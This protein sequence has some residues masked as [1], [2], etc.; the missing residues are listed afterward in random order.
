MFVEAQRTALIQ[1]TDIA[2]ETKPVTSAEEAIAAAR[3]RLLQRGS[4]PTLK[5]HQA[6]E[7]ADRLVEATLRRLQEIAR[8][9][10]TQIATQGYSFRA[11]AGPEA[12]KNAI[13][14]AIDDLAE[15]LE[16]V[17]L[18]LST[19]FVSR[20]TISFQSV[21]PRYHGL[22][23]A[24]AYFGPD[25]SRPQPL[26]VGT[27]QINYEESPSDAQERFGVWLERVVVA[28]LTEWR[29]TL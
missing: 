6:R 21:G 5:W 27:F 4:R 29:R 8:E 18:T 28:G 19:G 10:A 13:L 26:P 20:L 22:I 9:L 7:T 17:D 24:S 11:A 15:Y 25:S 14:L 2:Y 3:D 1:A 23:T 16:L 12:R